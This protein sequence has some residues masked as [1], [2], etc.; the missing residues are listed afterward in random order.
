MNGSLASLIPLQV[1]LFSER[2]F[3]GFPRSMFLC[4]LVIPSQILTTKEKAL[5]FTHPDIQKHK[6]KIIFNTKNHGDSSSAFH[7]QCDGKAPVLFVI[8]SKDY[9][10]VFGAL[11]HIPFESKSSGC[12]RRDDSFKNWIFRVRFV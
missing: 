12:W 7:S 3:L 4:S 11:S 6:W 8:K 10:H 1:S 9:N 2:S 5:L